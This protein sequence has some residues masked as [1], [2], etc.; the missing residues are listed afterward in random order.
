MVYTRSSSAAPSAR[1]SV[2][3]PEAAPHTPLA[4]SSTPSRLTRSQA[5]AN[6]HVQLLM[7]PDPDHAASPRRSRSRTRADGDN[8]SAYSRSVSRDSEA[9]E[10]TTPDS[11]RSRSTTPR[12]LSSRLRS[13]DRSGRLDGETVLEPPMLNVTVEVPLLSAISGGRDEN[14]SSTL[15]ASSPEHEEEEQGQAGE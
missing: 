7:T 10:A 5:R 11:R 12:G 15:E 2:M 3:S 1:S 13:R 6:G 4:G 9:A 14:R 8:R